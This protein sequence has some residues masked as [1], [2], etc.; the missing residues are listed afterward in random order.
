M[1]VF[2]ATDTEQCHYFNIT[3]DKECEY[4]GCES[5]FFMSQLSTDDYNLQLVSSTAQIVIEDR[6]ENET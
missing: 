1:L 4:D 5:K 3:D 6:K 2:S